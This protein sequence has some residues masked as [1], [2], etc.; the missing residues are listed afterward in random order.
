MR[1]NLM[2]IAGAALFL[3]AFL[4]SPIYAEP[5]SPPS[6][7]NKGINTAPTQ[8]SRSLPAGFQR[9]GNVTLFGVHTA[10]GIGLWRTDLT[11]E[12]T[13]RLKEFK[14][15]S[16]LEWRAM[17]SGILLFAAGDEAN[18]FELWRTD[19]TEAG[20]VLVKDILPG[21]EGSSPHDFAV[22]NDVLLF[23]CSDGVHA[24]G[25]WRSD[26]TEAGTFLVKDIVPG[27]FHSFSQELTQSG[28]FVF[29]SLDDELWRT[30]GTAPG[31]IPVR[32]ISNPR[33]L[34]YVE[35]TLFF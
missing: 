23:E 7:L 1:K 18:G 5:S 11:P 34:M 30:D 20:T 16:Y 24:Y 32:D 6:H 28:G 22:L 15:G 13:F 12:G 33:Q 27:P 31:T 19:G 8:D 35:G 3:T 4:G 10:T 25:L 26:G 14:S 9:V 21:P 29:F 17:V 2:T